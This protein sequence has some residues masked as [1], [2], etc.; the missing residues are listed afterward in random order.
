MSF[1]IGFNSNRKFVIS[2]TIFRIV[3]LKRKMQLTK[4]AFVVFATFVMNINVFNKSKIK[5]TTD[6]NQIDNLTNN[7]FSV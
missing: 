5:D 2:E 3:K 6:E 4:D 7:V 1:F